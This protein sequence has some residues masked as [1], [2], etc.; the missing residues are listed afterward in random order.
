MT[1]HLADQPKQWSYQVLVRAA[2]PGNEFK[3]VSALGKT[4]W[5]RLSKPK[6]AF[7][8]SR[9]LHFQATLQEKHLCMCTKH[10][11][12]QDHFTRGVRF[13][14]PKHTSA[15]AVRMLVYPQHEIRHYLQLAINNNNGKLGLYA[16]T[17]C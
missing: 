14:G 13:Q 17:W 9:H 11:L 10:M 4:I 5:Q 6:I 1:F 16:G 3:L 7:P 8:G 2:H 15:Q 12:T